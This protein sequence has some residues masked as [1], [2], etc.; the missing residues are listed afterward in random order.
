M[1]KALTI[2]AILAATAVLT[3]LSSNA[4]AGEISCKGLHGTNLVTLKAAQVEVGGV[5]QNGFKY[6]EYALSSTS[7]V[8]QNPVLEYNL[9]IKNSPSSQG[10]LV[11]HGLV[12]NINFVGS[13]SMSY[14]MLIDA[15]DLTRAQIRFTVESFYGGTQIGELIPLNCAAK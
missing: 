2:F 8:G 5:Y 14:T 7:T 4:F 6:S 11:Y 12:T 15:H 9:S 1:K 13:G 10:V 3:V